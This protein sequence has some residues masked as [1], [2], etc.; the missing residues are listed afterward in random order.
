MTLKQNNEQISPESI[1]AEYDKGKTRNERAGLYDKVKLCERFYE[2]DQWHG[3]KALTIR[4]VTMNFLRR[5]VSY[6]Q[7]MVVSDDIGYTL[8]PFEESGEAN[9]V[10]RVLETALDRVVEREKLKTLGRKSLRDASV[11]GDSAVYFWFDPAQRTGAGGVQGEIRAELLMNTNI[12]FG[13]PFSADVQSQPYLILSRRLPVGT[14]REQAKAAGVS[15]WERIKSDAA[16]EFKGGDEDGENEL[17]TELTRF[18]METMTDGDGESEAHVF[19]CK[20]AGGVLLQEPTDTGMTRYPV[21]YWNWIE[22]KNDCHGVRPL[23]EVINTQ[24]A[25]NRIWTAINLHIENLAF[26]KIVYNKSKFPNGWDSAPGRAVAIM[27]DVRDG[28]TNV[29]GGVPL[30]GLVTEVVQRM[31]DAARDCMGASD[32]AL[33]NVRPDNAGAIIAV[34]KASSAPL[35]LQRLAFYQFVEDYIRVLVDMMH[36]YYGVR[37]I[38][39]TRKD[40]DGA[41]TREK[42]LFDF[43]ALDPHALDLN[44]EVGAA[45][46]WSELTQITNLN[47]LMSAGIL[48]DAVDFLERVPKGLVPDIGGLIDKLK[49]QKQMQEEAPLGLGGAPERE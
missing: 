24:I 23:D 4:P 11:D 1:R 15:D 19:F 48:T 3:L 10:S 6:F 49:R 22:R 39:V 13:N 29:A 9:T 12:I 7:A 44:V 37:E 14:V 34:Q 27:G 42:V 33:G 2:G 40:E 17:V 43:S 28:V 38:S 26:P 20:T 25:I 18:W 8:T 5:V 35:E 32:A 45:S 31:I 41:E 21:A 47:G 16:G 30:S 36:A 46:Y